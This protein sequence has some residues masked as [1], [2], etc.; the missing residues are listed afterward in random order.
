MGDD[1]R[2]VDGVLIGGA[3]IGDTAIVNDITDTADGNDCVV[4]PLMHVQIACRTFPGVSSWKWR[5]VL[6]LE[7]TGGSFEHGL[8]SGVSLSVLGLADSVRQ[9]VSFRT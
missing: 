5:A 3:F 8:L 7:E 1:G 9:N 6:F 2:R 4:G